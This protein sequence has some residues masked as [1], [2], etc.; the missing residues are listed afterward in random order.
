MLQASTRL[1]MVPGWWR[2]WPAWSPYAAMAWSVLYGALALS[3]AAG[4]PGFPF[5]EGDP[6]GAAMGS[7][8]FAVPAEPPAHTGWATWAP[9][10]PWPFWGIAL[11]VA[12]S[13]Y[14]HR[15]HDQ[16]RVAVGLRLRQGTLR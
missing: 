14:Y 4:A 5:G 9:C 1:A 11:A 8:L 2:R 13:A 16:G 7:V 6:E 10:W 15:R 12:T 3:W